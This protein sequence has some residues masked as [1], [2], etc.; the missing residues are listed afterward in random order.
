MSSIRNLRK[1]IQRE[2]REKGI[3]PPTP[4][5]L[6]VLRHRRGKRGKETEGYA[7]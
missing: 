4:H 3:E 5:R 1:K 7:R 2:W 6:A